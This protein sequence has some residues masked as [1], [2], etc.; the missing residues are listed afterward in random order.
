MRQQLE[1]KGYLVLDNILN[2]E[3][4]GAITEVIDR[5]TAA[6]TAFRRSRDLFAIR[7]VFT[8]LPGLTSLVLTPALKK[9]VHDY[10]GPDYFISKTI[11]FDKPATSNWFVAYHQD[12][13]IAVDQ[14][15]EAPGYDPWTRK[16]EQF[17][18]QPPVALLERNLT[19]RIHLDDTDETNGTL[20]VVPG[21]HRKGIYRP[22]TID[23]SREREEICAVPAGGV[24]LMRPL[25]LHASSRSTA[26]KRRRVLH[27]ECSNAVLPEGMDWAERQRIF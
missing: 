16:D 10:A 12:L 25:L 26:E 24:M 14:R 15:T 4:C 9:I 1:D 11:Y 20:R 13:T 22:E 27:L 3:A 19:L 5:A 21:S 18:V 8:E 23:W 6:G 2:A 7:H 17:A